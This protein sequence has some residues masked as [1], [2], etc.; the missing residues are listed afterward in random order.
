MTETFIKERKHAETGKVEPVDIDDACMFLATSPTARWARSRAPAT[1]AATRPSTRSKSTARR[2]RCT[3]TCTT[4][5]GCSTSTTPTK[6]LVRG[7][8]RSTSPTATSV[9]EE[10]VGARLQIGYEHTFIHQFA[11]FL[12][13]MGKGQQVSPNFRD[14]LETQKVCDAV[15]ASAKSGQW[16]DVR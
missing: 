14:A 8:Q 12:D 16:V 6:S 13:A 1:P 4:C 9:H 2:L 7:W 10:L 15:L 3:G 5:I 11:D